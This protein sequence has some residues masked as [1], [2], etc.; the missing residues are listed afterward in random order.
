[1]PKCLRTC[2]H[3]KSANYNIGPLNGFVVRVEHKIQQLSGA[4][5]L[6]EQRYN[7]FETTN[8]RL[9]G[10]VYEISRSERHSGGALTP[11]GDTL[12]VM[13]RRGTIRRLTEGEKIVETGRL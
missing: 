6:L 10:T 13:N 3:K 11:W 8:V 12:L 9:R 1:M 2:K 7:L 5:S 4:P